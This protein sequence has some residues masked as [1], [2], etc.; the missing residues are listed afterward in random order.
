VNWLVTQVRVVA[1][2]AHLHQHVVELC[3]TAAAK[4]LA[5]SQLCH[6][7]LQVHNAAAATPAQW[8]VQGSVP[9]K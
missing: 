2:L 7:F 4:A 1:V 9:S 5:L 6:L 3:D 8:Q